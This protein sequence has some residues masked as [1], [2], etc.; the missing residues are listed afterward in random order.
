[1]IRGCSWLPGPYY[2]VPYEAHAG[3]S[4]LVEALFW[5]RVHPTECREILKMSIYAS[6]RLTF[7]PRAPTGTPASETSPELLNTG[8]SGSWVKSVDL[9]HR[10]STMSL[11]SH[12]AKLPQPY[13]A[14]CW[15][16][17]P[18]ILKLE[19][20]SPSNLTPAKLVRRY[21]QVS[22]GVFNSRRRPTYLDLR[23][24]S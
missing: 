23:R 2:G 24:V 19:N 18:E 17:G 8:A 3:L 15:T 12:T 4:K 14:N 16:S 9:G 13:A 20:L 5:T 21:K 6:T 22:E 1:M 10:P 11:G 7:L